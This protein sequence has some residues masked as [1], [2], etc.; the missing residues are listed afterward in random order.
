MRWLLISALVHALLL[1]LPVSAEQLAVDFGAGPSGGTYLAVSYS[2][3]LGL[4]VVKPVAGTF[5][6]KNFFDSPA[7][8]FG[9]TTLGVRAQSKWGFYAE[10]GVG[11]AVISR[12]DDRLG[13]HFQALIDAGAGF[14]AD[15][16]RVGVIGRHFSC[17]GLC[18]PNIGR[19]YVGV[20][21]GMEF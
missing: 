11:P 4:F 12:T 6:G 2:V 3:P 13:S 14:S 10:A 16:V 21:A 20:S 15:G 19:N 1:S 5:N 9:A 18:N 7:T 8:F 17:G